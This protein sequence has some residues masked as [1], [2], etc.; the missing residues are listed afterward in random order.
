MLWRHSCALSFRSH[1]N[2]DR[3]H[4]HKS[5]GCNMRICL[6]RAWSLPCPPI[7]CTHFQ[8]MRIL[9]I[10]HV[11]TSLWHRLLILQSHGRWIWMH[12]RDYERSPPEVTCTFSLATELVFGLCQKEEER[13]REIMRGLCASQHLTYLVHNKRKLEFTPPSVKLLVA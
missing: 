5:N 2:K 13:E 7:E 9:N 6:C 8:H 10:S 4:P 11:E 12:P 1:A 3:G